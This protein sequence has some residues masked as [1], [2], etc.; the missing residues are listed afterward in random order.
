MNLVV[1]ISDSVAFSLAFYLCAFV[2]T[3]GQ[4]CFFLYLFI[5]PHLYIIDFFFLLFYFK[6]V[7]TNVSFIADRCRCPSVGWYSILILPECIV[8][9]LFMLVLVS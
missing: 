9:P 8:K 5:F 2:Y 6:N 4:V 1:L 3:E 7:V